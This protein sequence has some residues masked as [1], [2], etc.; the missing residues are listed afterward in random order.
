[1]Q[2]MTKP[3]AESIAIPAA[4]VITAEF[5]GHLHGRT[6]VHASAKKVSAAYRIV[7]QIPADTSKRIVPSLHLWGFGAVIPIGSL[8]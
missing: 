3:Y 2:I 5:V 7:A 4:L 8:C 1:M 6:E